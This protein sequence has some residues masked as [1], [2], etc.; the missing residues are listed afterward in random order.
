MITSEDYSTS[1]YTPHTVCRT[2]AHAFEEP[3]C[4]YWDCSNGDCTAC[5]EKIDDKKNDVPAKSAPPLFVIEDDEDEI[6]DD[7]KEIYSGLAD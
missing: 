1:A 4:S 2:G 6:P 7:L 3:E 5:K